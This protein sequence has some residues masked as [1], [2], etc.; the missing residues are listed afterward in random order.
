METQ[1]NYTSVI[2]RCLGRE[3]RSFESTDEAVKALSSDYKGQHVSLVRVK[4]SNGMSMVE[5]LSI[6]KDGSVSYTYQDKPL[7]L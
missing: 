7:S 3:R 2:V 4:A 1:E 6:G 5:F